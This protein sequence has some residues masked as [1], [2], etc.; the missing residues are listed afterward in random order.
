M[1]ANASVSLRSADASVDKVGSVVV[2]ASELPPECAAPGVLIS[3]ANAETLRVRARTVAVQ[4]AF[5]V[6]MV[7]LQFSFFGLIGCDKGS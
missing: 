1:S 5:I 2:T 4:I 3:P 7:S 6:F